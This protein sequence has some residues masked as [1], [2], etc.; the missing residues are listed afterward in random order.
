MNR[1]LQHASI[2]LEKNDDSSSLLFPY[3]VAGLV[4]LICVGFAFQY[5]YS[6]VRRVC[7]GF[8][9]PVEPLSGEEILANLSDDQ[10]RA[11]MQAILTKVC[12]VRS[13]SCTAVLLCCAVLLVALIATRCTVDYQVLLIL[14]LTVPCLRFFSFHRQPLFLILPN[15]KKANKREAEAAATLKQKRMCP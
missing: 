9:E 2:A 12:K 7:F 14:N 3:A 1:K 10:R 4:C 13:S 5:A 11:V 15:A 6:W 8:E